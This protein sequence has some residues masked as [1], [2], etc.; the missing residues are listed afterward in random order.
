MPKPLFLGCTLLL[1]L[2]SCKSQHTTSGFSETNRKM[3]LILQDNYSGIEEEQLLVIKNQKGLE[4]FFGKVNR[5]RKPGIPIP[6]IDF[7]KDMLI[8]WCGGKNVSIPTELQ[9]E[10]NPDEILVKRRTNKGFKSGNSAITNPFQIYKMPT[11][12]QSVNFQ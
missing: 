5:T 7:E 10:T 1:F 8:V 11:T 9:L 6:Q 3:E 12:S 4:E 2:C